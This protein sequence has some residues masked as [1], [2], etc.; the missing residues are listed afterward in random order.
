[1]FLFK[2]HVCSDNMFDTECGKL[3]FIQLAGGIRGRLV[4]Q[5]KAPRMLRIAFNE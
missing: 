2:N 5:K 4:G 3:K 1:M